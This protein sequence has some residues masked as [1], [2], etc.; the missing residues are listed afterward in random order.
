M[1]ISVKM[2]KLDVTMANQ[3]YVKIDLDDQVRHSQ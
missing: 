1:K 3:Q 2:L